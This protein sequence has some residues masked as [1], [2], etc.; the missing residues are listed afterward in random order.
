MAGERWVR[1]DKPH[2]TPPDRTALSRNILLCRGERWL[3]FHKVLI[4]PPSEK[5][6]YDELFGEFLRAMHH[7][8]GL[9]PDT[10]RGYGSRIAKFLGWSGN[11]GIDFFLVRLNDVD[12]FL[13]EKHAERIV[14]HSEV[15]NL[16]DASSKIVYVIIPIAD[17]EGARLGCWD[18]ARIRS[19][20]EV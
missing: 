17:V 8:W 18:E 3:R 19:R 16:S 13:D 5:K 7:L 14:G 20:E 4:S 10:L 15:I 9:A 1:D 2:M 11:H 6:P 12:Q